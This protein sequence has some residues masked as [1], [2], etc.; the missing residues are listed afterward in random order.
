MT[1]ASTA[2]GTDAEKVLLAARELSENAQ[3]LAAE[4]DRFLAE[5]RSW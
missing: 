4:V 5:I 1:T 3:T 2:S